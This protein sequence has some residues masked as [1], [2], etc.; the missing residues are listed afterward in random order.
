MEYHQN[1]QIDGRFSLVNSQMI[2][3]LLCSLFLLGFVTKTDKT[4]LLFFDK[5]R[6]SNRMEIIDVVTD[7]S[8]GTQEP[9]RGSLRGSISAWLAW[10]S[11]CAKS[12]TILP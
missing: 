10:N 5:P 1:S 12:V 8:C 11:S 9:L 3:G 6:L 4:C 2:G 7:P